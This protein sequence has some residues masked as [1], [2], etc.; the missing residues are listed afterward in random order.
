MDSPFI[1]D[2]PAH[3][4]FR[5]NRRTMVDPEILA[6]ERATIFDR[7][8]LYLGH[9]SEVAQPGEYVSR[10]VGGRSLVLCRDQQGE[11]RVWLNSCTHRGAT[12]CR[13]TKGHGRF[14]TCFYH[15]WSFDL[16]GNLAALPD[17]EAYGPGF[18]RSALALAAPPRFDSYRGFVFVAYDPAVPDLAEH[19]AGAREY[20]DLVCDQSDG[21]MT[22]LPGT[23]E[24]SIQANWKLL[25]ENSI[26]GYHAMSTHATYMDYLMTAMRRA[27]E[28]M[29]EELAPPALT[30]HAVDLGNG[31]A[32]IEYNAPWARPV[33]RWAPPLD[34]DL[35]EPISSRRAALVAR[36][37]AER[38][39][40]ICDTSRNLLIFPNL[41]VNDIMAVTVRTFEPI[42]PGYMHV[43]AWE[44]APAD[45]SGVLH[46][47]RLDNFLTFLGPGGLATP[48]DVE[49]LECCQRGYTTWR[50]LPWSDISRG[51]A[52]ERPGITDEHQMR[53]FWRRWHELIGGGPAGHEVPVRLQ[54]V[55]GP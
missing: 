52:Q 53:V 2:D 49:A 31:H 45:E 16:A 13:E 48:D 20:L 25:V 40:R 23:Q 36:H 42:D 14:L 34:P 18:D 41:I 1:I 21:A 22:I 24:Y 39:R 11:L 15:A 55:A 27:A 9:E 6:A 54:A 26:D 17:A 12:V 7:T 29:G 33:A 32:V 3:A 51:M 47:V 19:L 44:L 50:E 46:Q 8:W 4:T 5:V 37:G 35:R 28:A 30:G 43:R 38:A 10:T